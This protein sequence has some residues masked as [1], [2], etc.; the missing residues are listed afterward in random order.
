[1][2]RTETFPQWRADLTLLVAWAGSCKHLVEPLGQEARTI[3][4]WAAGDRVP[5]VDT[6]QAIRDLRERWE[7]E[8]VRSAEAWSILPRVQLQLESARREKS[9]EMVDQ[10]IERLG[11]IREAK[12]SLICEA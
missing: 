11:E 10:L 3:Q 8:H 4:K 5:D 12:G 2:A 1:M 6:K 7:D 9:W